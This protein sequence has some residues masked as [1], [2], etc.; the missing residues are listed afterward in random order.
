ME[1]VYK[2]Y[3]LKTSSIPFFNFGKQH[4]TTNACQK[5]DIYIYIYLNIYTACCIYM[6]IYIYI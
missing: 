2:K 1:N 3:A 4:K 5:R 6:Y